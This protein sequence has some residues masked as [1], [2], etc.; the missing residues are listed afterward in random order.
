MSADAIIHERF[1]WVNKDTLEYD[2]TID[3]PRSWDVS[4]S[5]KLPMRRTEDPLFDIVFAV[6]SD[7]TGRVH[8][9]IKNQDVIFGLHDLHIVIVGARNHR[10]ASIESGEASVHCGAAFRAGA[11]ENHLTISGTALAA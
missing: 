9:L 7:N 5:A 4:W 2:F 1:R 11:L 8:H 10:R 3:D 6:Q